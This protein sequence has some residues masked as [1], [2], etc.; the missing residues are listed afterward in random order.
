MRG[1]IGLELGRPKTVPEC[2]M[3]MCTYTIH[4]EAIPQ[5]VAAVDDFLNHMETA[6][7]PPDLRKIIFGRTYVC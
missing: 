6:I 1:G 3:H 5:M 2:Q 4:L 7:G